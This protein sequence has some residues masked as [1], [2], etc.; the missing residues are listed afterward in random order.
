MQESKPRFTYLI[1]RSGFDLPVLRF[2]CEV[3]D[4]LT[5][6]RYGFD[7][8]RCVY[9]QNMVFSNT[10]LTCETSISSPVHWRTII[11]LC[12]PSAELREFD[13]TK[14]WEQAHSA[15][16][17]HTR[18]LRFVRH[19]SEQEAIMEAPWWIL[20]WQH[21]PRRSRPSHSRSEET[22]A[23]RRSK[24]KSTAFWPLSWLITTIGTWTEHRRCLK[25]VKRPWNPTLK[26]QSTCFMADR[27]RNTHVRRRA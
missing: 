9:T 20:L 26:V 6:I 27:F 25:S 7:N 4:G 19:A 3:F 24:W 15:R 16:D 13:A 17:I 10:E 5:W 11:T 12:K 23:T 1:P 2:W 18:R 21:Q 8:G 22:H 14:K